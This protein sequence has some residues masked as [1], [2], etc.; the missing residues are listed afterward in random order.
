MPERSIVVVRSQRCN[1]TQWT[2]LINNP[3]VNAFQK[4]TRLVRIPYQREQLFQLVY[5]Q[6]QLAAFW[7]H[8]PHRPQQSAF[9]FLNLP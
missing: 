8:P 2:L 5:H 9:I 7:Q 6:H 1:H 3:L 4:E